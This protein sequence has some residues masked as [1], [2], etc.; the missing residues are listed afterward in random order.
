M[1]GASPISED[2]L[3]R[4]MRLFKC[5]FMQ[6]YGMTETTGL[7][8]LL[9]PE[10][11]DPGGPR[12]HLLRSCGKAPGALEIKLLGSDGAPVKEDGDVGEIWIRGPSIMKGYWQDP[13][14][15]LI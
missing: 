6:A 3:V 12:A 7:G 4:S 10:D 5:G 14:G 13:P 2:V 11:H 8:S 15:G 1:Y 9:L